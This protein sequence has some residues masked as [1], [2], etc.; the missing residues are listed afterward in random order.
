MK[1]FLLRVIIYVC[2]TFLIFASWKLSHCYVTDVVKVECKNC[3]W[4]HD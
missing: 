3:E 1:D 2:I 4:K